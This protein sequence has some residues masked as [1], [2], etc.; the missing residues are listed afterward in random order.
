MSSSSIPSCPAATDAV[1]AAT[2]ATAGRDTVTTGSS[3]QQPA[4]IGLIGN[5]YVIRDGDCDYAMILSG[6]ETQAVTPQS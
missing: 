2:Q 1:S 5:E 3:L 4:Q 6:K